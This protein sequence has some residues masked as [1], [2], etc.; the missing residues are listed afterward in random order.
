MLGALTGGALEPMLVE[1][2]TVRQDTERTI[3][4]QNVKRIRSAL[5]YERS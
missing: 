4:G 5:L 3:M 1:D 2:N